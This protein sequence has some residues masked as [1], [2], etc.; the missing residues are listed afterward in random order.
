MVFYAMDG[1][2]GMFAVCFRLLSISGR[3]SVDRIVT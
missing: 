2:V 3:K 1:I